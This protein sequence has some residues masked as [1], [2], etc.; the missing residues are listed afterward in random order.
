MKFYTYLTQ[1]NGR[2]DQVGRFARLIMEHTEP[3]HKQLSYRQWHDW[4]MSHK[5]DSEAREA[6][7]RAWMEYAGKLISLERYRNRKSEN[8]NQEMKRR[9]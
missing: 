4:L 5:P 2:N 1:Q 6:F 8:I 9:P 7:Q 3:P